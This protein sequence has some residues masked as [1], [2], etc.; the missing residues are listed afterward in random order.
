MQA[1]DQIVSALGGAVRAIG[2]RDIEGKTRELNHALALIS[3][4]RRDLDFKAGGEVA[5]VMDRFYAI[6]RTQILEA[7]A[8]LSTEILQQ[9]ISQFASQREA[10][11]QVERANSTTSR[12]SD[13]AAPGAAGR[14]EHTPMPSARWSA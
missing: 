9:A 1:Y 14:E 6:A 13:P 5:L 10:W 11:E 3:H 12:V 8:L 2:D 4:L 7:S